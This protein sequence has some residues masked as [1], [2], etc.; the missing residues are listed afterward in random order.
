VGTSKAPQK[1]LFANTVINTPSNT[2][3]KIILTGKQILAN[4]RIKMLR[5][6][7]QHSIQNRI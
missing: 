1:F 4:K 3:A 2:P 5:F 6:S 7:W